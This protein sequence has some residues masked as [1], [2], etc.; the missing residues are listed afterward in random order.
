MSDLQ[1]TLGDLRRELKEAG[2]LAPED[3]ALL[4]ST[5][6]DIQHLLGRDAAVKSEAEPAPGEVLEGAAVRLEAEHPGV[7]G[8]VRAL[9]DALAKAGI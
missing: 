7:A 4:E 3:R 8:A 9:V 2:E 1:H 6:H 5:M